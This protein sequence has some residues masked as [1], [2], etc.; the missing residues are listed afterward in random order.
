LTRNFDKDIEPRPFGRG[1]SHPEFEYLSTPD[2][3]VLGYIYSSEKI[4]GIEWVTVITNKGEYA[5][6]HENE[7]TG[8]D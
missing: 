8:L 2:G 7:V 4:H 6:F 1:F 5:R 3:V